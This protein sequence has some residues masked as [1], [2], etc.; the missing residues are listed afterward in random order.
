M[1][2]QKLVFWIYKSDQIREWWTISGFNN[3]KVLP[4][5]GRNGTTVFR[6]V[7]ITY[8]WNWN[9]NRAKKFS[10]EYLGGK[11][12]IMFYGSL[13]SVIL[14]TTSLNILPLTE[15][16]HLSSLRLVSILSRVRIRGPK[17]F[18]LVTM[19]SE[20]EFKRKHFRNFFFVLIQC[21]PKFGSFYLYK[22]DHI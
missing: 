19:K 12:V 5:T 21:I 14:A 11:S 1:G 7:D 15:H 18:I 3:D 2:D 13:E 22:E 6:Y 9:D 4:N 10:D 17:Y 20:M 16:I 8:I